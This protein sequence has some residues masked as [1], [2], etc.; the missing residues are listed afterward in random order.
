MS[1]PLEQH[2][3]LTEKNGRS[4]HTAAVAASSAADTASPAATLL[5]HQY[6]AAKDVSMDGLPTPSQPSNVSMVHQREVADVTSPKANT[7]SRVAQPAIPVV[8]VFPRQ[9][10]KALPAD[11][12]QDAAKQTN[13]N[14]SSESTPQTTASE[15][16]TASETEATDASQSVLPPQPK[17]S[18][19]SW[20]GLF[21]KSSA[22]AAARLNGPNGSTEDGFV[23][24]IGSTAHGSAVSSGS[25][26]SRANAT[27]RSEAIQAY[28]VDSNDLIP[29]LEPRGLINTGNMC[30]MNS[31]RIITAEG[32][33]MY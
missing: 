17:A 24:G 16:V 3:V 22:S 9:S 8:P 15:A 29:F 25:G 7:A 30:Y 1:L 19:A 31:V 26:F 13:Q 14:G 5:S 27:S 18:P 6:L 11:K 33:V 21:A 4:A 32:Q 20:A 10:A 12:S 2:G 28:R 23:N